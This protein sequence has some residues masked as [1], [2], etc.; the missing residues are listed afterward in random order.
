MEQI[1]AE[2]KRWSRARRERQTDRQ[3]R[4]PEAGKSTK[5]LRKGL[6]LRGQNDKG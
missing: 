6:I 4:P 1:E 5:T 3:M 2:P